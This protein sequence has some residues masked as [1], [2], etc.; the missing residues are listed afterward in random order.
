MPHD[1]RPIQNR[2]VDRLSEFPAL[3]E[4]TLRVD[5][6]LCVTFAE[7]YLEGGGITEL[8]GPLALGMK[9]LNA[10]DLAFYAIHIRSATRSS[11]HMYT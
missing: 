11:M 10:E 1:D 6:L 7:R 2:P 8:W 9:M 5:T 3:P 4:A